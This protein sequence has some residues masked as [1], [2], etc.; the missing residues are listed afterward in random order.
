MPNLQGTSLFVSVL[1]GL[2][3]SFLHAAIPTHWL[4][5]VLAHR[6]QGWSFRKTLAVTALAGSFHVLTT[7]LLGILI[8]TLGLALD[9][10]LG[11]Y[12]PVLASTSLM[13]VAAYYLIRQLRGHEHLHGPLHS[14]GSDRHHESFIMRSDSSEKSTEFQGRTSST[15]Y[16]KL[17]SDRV[18]IVG[19][20]SLLLFS[21]CEGFLPVYFAG[22]RHGWCGFA[23]LSLILLA[24]TLSGMLL[25]TSLS[26][27]GLARFDL[28]RLHD[29]E[30]YIMAAVL[31]L[32]G[33]AVLFIEQ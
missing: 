31:F 33:L 23:V 20:V 21:P 27:L 19:L 5:F 14:P 13:T 32:L 26:L 29:S 2:S 24:G 8:V 12:F 9:N 17:P 18:V 16:K 30:G 6:S 4:P 28:K 7:A 15:V 3:V 11:V 22:I 10:Y 1:T 25:F